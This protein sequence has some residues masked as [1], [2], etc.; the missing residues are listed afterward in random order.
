MKYVSISQSYLVLVVRVLQKNVLCSI[1]GWV[2][3]H[4]VIVLANRLFSNHNAR[5]LFKSMPFNALNSLIWFSQ[6]TDVGGVC[7]VIG[8]NVHLGVCTGF[9]ADSCHSDS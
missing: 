5:H 9:L 6:I 8:E 1:H 2:L 7:N 3:V 4:H